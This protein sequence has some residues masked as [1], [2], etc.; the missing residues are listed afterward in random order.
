MQ[1]IKV[2]YN[3][4]ELEFQLADDLKVTE[5]KI[6]D[7]PP[8]ADFDAAVDA[9]LANPIGSKPLAELVSP[10]ETAAVIISDMTR[11]SYRTDLYLCKI[12]DQLNAG[13]I[14]DEEITVVVACGYH[15]P[16]NEEEKIILAGKEAY[17][18]VKIEAHDCHADDLVDYG[19]TVRGN[20]VLI[21][22]TVATADK[23]IL[24]GGICYHT[25]AGF[26]GGRKSIAPGVAGA[27]TIEGNHCNCFSKEN[28][29]ELYPKATS[30]YL[31]GNPVSEEMFEIAAM[32]KPAFL[33]N[34]IVN[35][36][37]QFVG[38]VAGDWR[39]AYLVG[40]EK[41]REIYG[42]EMHETFD[43]A[44]LSNGGYPKDINLFQSVK[45]LHNACFVM[46]PGSS[47]VLCADCF[48]GFGPA[49]YRKGFTD[50]ASYNELWDAQSKHYDPEMAISLLTMRYLQKIS[51]V[52][53]ISSLPDEDVRLAGM[54]P[55]KTPEEAWAHILEDKPNL[56]KVMVLPC[57]AL[58]CPILKD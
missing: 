44:I 11:A 3:K 13:G 36:H 40:V 38:L 16:P 18:R 24:T 37:G 54:I 46:N 1:H 52:Y 26:G 45:G 47:A 57:G 9:A 6:K 34:V 48:D 8:I 42:I 32:V 41:I 5:L 23:V 25:F 43:A 33:V 4:T 55:V 2:P 15:E 19:K 58:T 22:H 30:G 21:N 56:K 35:D 20:E 39:E 51:K 28:R 10:G 50:F 27:S 49:G 31:D 14:P 7:C 17:G 12:L 53:L 29:Y